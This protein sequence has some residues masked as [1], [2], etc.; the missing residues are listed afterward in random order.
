MASLNPSHRSYCITFRPH[1]GVTDKQISTLSRWIKKSSEYYFVITEKEDEARHIHA[2]IFLNKKT[3]RSNL[4][5]TLSRLFKEL[6]HEEKAVF[7]RGIK[8]QY[9]SDFITEYM[10]KGD[11]T[12]VIERNLPEIATL[13]KY[14]AE[15]PDKR[16]KGPKTTD[17]FYANLEKLWFEHKR[18]IEECNPSNL[19]NFLMD[20][21]N[22]KRLIRVIADN[23][24]IF[25]ISCALSRYI[26]R[27]TSFHVEPEPF[28]QDV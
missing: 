13:D 26:N 7:N 1:G 9:N 11:D 22:N 28:H 20:M 12:V 10:N 23:R 27:E 8:A 17:P 14:F 18:P 16:K 25:S 6:T 21:M 5:I 19:R 2:S 3:T 4:T 24:K 15:V